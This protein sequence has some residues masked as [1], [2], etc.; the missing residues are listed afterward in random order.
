M[1]RTN[2][3]V[4]GAVLLMTLHAAA[5]QPRAGGGQGAAM[6]AA[7]KGLTDVPG[8]K[9]GHVTMTERP[10]GC[11][12]ILT[13]AGAVAGVDVRGSAPGTMETDLLNPLNLVQQVNAIFLS[14]GSAFGLDVATGVR[15]YLYEKNIG[16]DTRVAKVPIV[17]GAILYDLNIGG[18]PEIWPTAECGYRAATAATG[19]PIAEGNVGAGA[20]ATVG[21]S[22]GGGGAMKGGTGTASIVMSDGLIVAALV[23]VNA[24][25][26]IVDP[27]TGSVVA[28]VRTADGRALA[29]ARTLLRAGRLQQAMPGQNTT[30]G[31]VATNARLTKTQ[32]TKVAQMAHDGVARAIYPS[33]TMGDGD[34]MFAL[35]TGGLSADADVSRVGALGAEMV[36]DAIMRAARQATGIPG[37]PAARDLQR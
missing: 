13:E 26:D 14:G 11:T 3:L 6:K 5:Q 36:S 7:S 33:H 1:V 20:G 29:D 9:V 22:G 34:T 28:G 15:R 18:H 31:V 21:K 30:I 2:T 24:V 27:A 16:F 25:G 12:V 35:A 17:P 19:G 10:T 37:Y 4:A 8:I 32:A 23:A